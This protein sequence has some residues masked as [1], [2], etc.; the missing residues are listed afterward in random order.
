MSFFGR[1]AKQVGYANVQT[2]QRS[3]FVFQTACTNLAYQLSVEILNDPGPSRPLVTSAFFISASL[4]GGKLSLM[5]W[6]G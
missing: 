4:A 3:H 1:I 2:Y 6:V 5:G